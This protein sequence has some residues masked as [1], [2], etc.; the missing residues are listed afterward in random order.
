[1]GRFRIA[2]LENPKPVGPH[3]PRTLRKVTTVFLNTVAIE[4]V[5]AYWVARLAV[6]VRGSYRPRHYIGYR[7]DWAYQSLGGCAHADERDVG[8]ARE[9]TWRF[10]ADTHTDGID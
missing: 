3:A 7:G 2:R 1:M 8:K 6:R 4:V 5:I 9:N 10:S